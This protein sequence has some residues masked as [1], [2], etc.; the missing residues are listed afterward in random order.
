MEWITHNI[1]AITN[2]SKISQIISDW[3]IFGLRVLYPITL[4]G[5]CIKIFM[6]EYSPDDRMWGWNSRLANAIS[7]GL[8][9]EIITKLM[10]DKTK[11]KTKTYDKLRHMIYRIQTDSDFITSHK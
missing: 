6:Y 3:L 10:T 5:I 11:Y 4:T 2:D 8:Y 7:K 9:F 1:Y